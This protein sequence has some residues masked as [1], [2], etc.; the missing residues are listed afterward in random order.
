VDNF[1]R[2]NV[3]KNMIKDVIIQ[4]GNPSNSYN[5]DH[6]GIFYMLLA[7]EFL[8]SSYTRLV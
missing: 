5:V 6:T 2:R 4:L 3:R 8:I 7:N 1:L